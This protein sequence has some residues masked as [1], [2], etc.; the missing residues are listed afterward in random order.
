[1]SYCPRESWR[2]EVKMLFAEERV[3]KILN[4]FSKCFL[5]ALLEA[6]SFL[7]TAKETEQGFTSVQL[8]KNQSF[9]SFPPKLTTNV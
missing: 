4:L 2:L 6:V 7:H 3:P 5:S 1:M 9:Y 8:H